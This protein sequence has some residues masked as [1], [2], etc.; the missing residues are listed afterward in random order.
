MPIPFLLAPIVIKLGIAAVSAATAGGGVAIYKNNKH[1][2]DKKNWQDEKRKLQDKIEECQQEIVKKQGKISELQ[3]KLKIKEEEKL[4]LTKELHECDRMIDALERKQREHESAIKMII[5]LI[6]FRYPAFKK[7]SINLRALLQTNA[8]EKD[9][10][11]LKIADTEKLQ[12]TWQYDIEGIERE[13][14]YLEGEVANKEEL[15]SQCG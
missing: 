9:K 7:E 1:N 13:V 2:K 11:L 8:D 5:A 12:L 14:L 15:L 6:T 4:K 3:E 10:T